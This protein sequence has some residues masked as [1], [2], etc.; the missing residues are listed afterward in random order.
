MVIPLQTKTN[1]GVSWFQGS[2]G[3]R[4]STVAGV[5]RAAFEKRNC[6][7]HRVSSCFIIVLTYQHKGNAV[8]FRPCAGRKHDDMSGPSAIPLV[9]NLRLG[10]NPLLAIVP[11][12]ASIH[13]RLLARYYNRLFAF[14]LRS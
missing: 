7:P 9:P 1:N 2:A 4:P 3:F 13:E 12:N 6:P 11:S 8:Y 10:D 14:S 5:I